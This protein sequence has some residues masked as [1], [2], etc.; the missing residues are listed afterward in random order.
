MVSIFFGITSRV[1]TYSHTVGRFEFGGPGFLYPMDMVLSKTGG[2]IHSVNRSYQ[3]T[4][5]GRTGTRVN[6]VTLDE[7]AI[8][9]FGSYGEG[10][11]EFIWPSAIALD[12][13]GNCYVTDEWLNR[14]SIF[15]KSGNFVG[16]WGTPGSKDGELAKPSG[17]EFDSDDN[18]YVVDSANHR[19][20]IFTK[21][22]K[23]LSKFGGFGT[24]DGQ[25]NYPWGI[26][27]DSQGDLYVA[28]WRNDRI[29]KFDAE[30]TFLA[31]FGS[32]GSMVGQFNHPTGVAVDRDGDIYVADW[33][34][35]RVQI[36]TQDFKYINQLTGQ[37][38]ISKW[39]MEQLKS[40]PSMIHQYQ[41]VSDPA[42][43]ER[44]WFPIAVAVDDEGTIAVL[45]CV[46]HRLQV[47]KK[48]VRAAGVSG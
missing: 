48:E 12:S 41:T 46:R 10:D 23:F 18:L 3:G 15:D 24:G 31:K 2:V 44:F 40:N 47:Y 11:G 14:I 7:Q 35:H 25:F 45:E 20:Q 28:D 36:F 5:L 27:K 21:E 42:I 13:Q 22:G 26:T 4:P 19:V 17:L 34:N 8:M 16:K 6:V 30:G 29:Q 38:T 39:A 33:G 32:S 37:A 43:L 9:D 1:F